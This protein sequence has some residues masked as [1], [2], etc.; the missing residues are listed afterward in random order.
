MFRQLLGCRTPLLSRLKSSAVSDSRNNI[1]ADIVGCVGVATLDRP[2]KLN[3]LT[4]DMVRELHVVY[5]DWLSSDRVK[6]IVQRGAGGKAFCAGGDVAAVR[7]EA[8]AGGSLPH[9]F[10]YEEYQLNHRIA[11]MWARYKKPQVAIWDGITMGGGVGLSV[12]GRFRVATERTVFAKPETAIGLFPDVGGTHMLPRV[13]GGMPMGLFIGLTGARLGAADLMYSGL[14]THFIPSDRLDALVPALSSLGD[15]ADDHDAVDGVLLELGDGQEP[16]Q[17]SAVL[18]PNAAA[19]GRCF[20]E[21][22]AEG[23]FEALH[24]EAGASATNGDGAA[25]WARRAQGALAR[26]SPT[27]I[28]VTMEA[29]RRHASADCTIGAALQAEYRCS[30]RATLHGQPISDFYEGIRAVLVDKDP[31]S[32]VWNPPT[33]D[34]VTASA[35]AA[36]FEPLPSAHPRGELQF[37]DL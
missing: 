34:A 13:T 4:L 11:N 17:E 5:N 33:V 18:V 29:C 10:F 32:A 19:I 26:M 3:S 6:C 12:H 31:K 7:V 22:E 24:V 14:A 27:S 15:K 16:E 35:V 2:S 1:G 21:A 23:I 20:G 28:K 36:Y 37:L 9:D 25:Q 8:L 30:Q